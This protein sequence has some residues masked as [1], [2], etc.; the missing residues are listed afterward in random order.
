LRYGWKGNG[1]KAI[2]LTVDGPVLGHRLNE[3][4]NSFVLPEGV[5]FPNIESDL[6]PSALEGAADGLKYGKYTFESITRT[7]LKSARREHRLGN[8]HPLGEKQYHVTYLGKRK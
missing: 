5:T 3:F 2:L 4:R 8:S 1:F 7:R 6:D